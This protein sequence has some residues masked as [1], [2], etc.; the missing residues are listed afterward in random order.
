[1]LVL[2]VSDRCDQRCAH[3]DLWQDGGRPALSPEQRRRVVDEA[4]ALGIERALFTGGEPLLSPDLEPLA[5]RLREAGVRTL[6]A[7]TG[8]GLVARAEAVGRLFHEV[9]VSLDGPT[10]AVHDAVRGVAGFARVA[11]GVASLARV[12]PGVRRVAR[13]TLHGMN[14]AA[15]AE[16]PGA[17][18]RLGF[19]HV[20]FL[21][22]DVHSPAFGGH[23]GA[24]RQLAPSP[25]EVAGFRRA[26]RRLE[27]GGAFRDGFVLESPA[28]LRRLAEHLEATAGG[29]GWRRPD[30]DAPWWSVMVEAD[31]RV[32]PCFFHEPVGEAGEGLARL[33]GSPRMWA[34]L[35]S[36][37]DGHPTCDACV[38]PKARGG[39][40]PGWRPA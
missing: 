19:H 14:L 35:R 36:I 16:L 28:R 18:R 22:I 20:S 7:T 2:S 17:A 24:R 40:V 37:R 6:L 1:L 33:R 23:P 11:A 15:F 8:M 5:R 12:A 25:R 29:G 9:Y 26:L 32:R 13:C 39:P 30:C 21:P 10:P 27:A 4:L 38:C 31:G 3:C 34:A